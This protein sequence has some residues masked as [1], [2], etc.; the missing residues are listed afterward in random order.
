MVSSTRRSRRPGARARPSQPCQEG[1]ASAQPG[2]S[3]RSV[4][5]TQPREHR[6]R[7]ADASE[8]RSERASDQRRGAVTSTS[9]DRARRPLAA[10]IAPT[11]ERVRRPSRRPCATS[12]T[13]AG[14]TELGRRFAAAGHELHLVGGSVRDALL[15]Q[16][17]GTGC[18]R[19]RLH[20]RRPPRAGP[21]RSQRLGRPPGT[22]ASTSARSAR[23]SAAAAWRS[24]LSAPTCT[25]G[26]PAT[27]TSPSVTRW[28]TT[29]S[30]AIS[31]STRWPCRWPGRTVTDPFG[32]L[33]TSSPAAA[34]T[35]ARAGGVVR[36][37]P[38][39]DAAGRPV[40]RPARVHPGAGVVD[41]DDGDGRRARPDHR[42]SGCRPS[43]SKLIRTRPRAA[44]TCWST[45]DWPTGPAGAA[46]AAAGERRAPPAQGRLRAHADRAGPGHRAGEGRGRRAPDLML[47]LAALLHDI[48]KPAT[49]R[50]E[51]GGAGQ[52]PPPRGGRRE[53]GPQAAARAAV[54][55]GVVD[56]VARLTFLHLRFHGYG[57]GEWTDSAVRRY[58]TDAGDLLPRLHK[59]V[60]ADCTTRN[61]RRAAALRRPTTT[62]RSGS[63]SSRR[64]RTWRGCVPTWTATR[65][66][67]C[68][69]SARARR[70]AG[71][72][73]SSTDAGEV[74]RRESWRYR[75][76][77]RVRCRSPTAQRRAACC[78]SSSPTAPACAAGEQVAS[79]GDMITHRGVG[80]LASAVAVEAQ[81]QEDQPGDRLDDVF[82]VA[83]RGQPLAHR[84]APTASWWWKETRPRG[85]AGGWP[86]CRCR[87]A[88]PPAEHQVRLHGRRVGLLQPDRCSRTAASACRRPCAGGARRSPGAVPAAPAGRRRPGRVDEQLQA[89]RGASCSSV[90]EGSTCTRSA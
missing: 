68:S 71:P 77:Q 4:A 56:D 54:P 55:E 41:G 64:R 11:G 16:A 78:G 57:T 60:R 2:W 14:V 37:R 58:V 35:P 31:R 69:A 21:R 22:P 47:R 7:P 86:A 76:S 6:G 85:R 17:G 45:P 67:R 52:L 61:K 5:S 82:R 72:G 63:P 10:G 44:W 65:S 46:G 26:S 87:A 50:F 18:R 3:C 66:W 34:D 81:V 36:G 51:A 79:I 40:R 73:V 88:A 83:Q 30:A 80:A 9:S 33:A 38:A 53:A 74:L 24:P 39:A 13:L 15:R 49:R 48:G 1:S 23:R 27:P 43:C 89:A 90:F 20:H 8:H 75:S 32:G 84:L 28:P 12:S 70:S 25:T 42:R 29:C 19:P 59:L 62:W